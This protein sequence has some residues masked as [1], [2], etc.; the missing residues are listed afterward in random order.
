MCNWPSTNG[1]AINLGSTT[2]AAA[3][4]LELSDAE[5]DRITAG[6]LR[7]GTSSS[8]E[9]SITRSMNPAQANTLHLSSGTSIMQPGSL[10]REI[11]VPQ[12]AAEATGDITLNISN[13]FGRVAALSTAGAVYLNDANNMIVGAVDGL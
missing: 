11:T 8:G 13:D 10:P 7:I 12:F 2:D 5:L 6:T 3:S 9:I 4:T 1:V